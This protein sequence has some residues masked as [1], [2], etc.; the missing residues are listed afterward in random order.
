M[1]ETQ[2]AKFDYLAYRDAAS[3]LA[4]ADYELGTAIQLF[5]QSGRQDRVQRADELFRAV[6][7]LRREVEADL[8]D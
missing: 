4:G 1:P 3:A 7:D 8:D 6:L 5:I 2:G